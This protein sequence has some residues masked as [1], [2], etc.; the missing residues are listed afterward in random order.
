[1]WVARGVVVGGIGVFSVVAAKVRRSGHGDPG[2]VAAVDFVTSLW[3][4]V[5]TG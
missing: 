4:R 1:M 5:T 2:F 3:L